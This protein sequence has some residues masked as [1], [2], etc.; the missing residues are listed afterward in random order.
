LFVFLAYDFHLFTGEDL[1]EGEY[2][3]YSDNNGFVNNEN[4]RNTPHVRVCL[5]VF[6]GEKQR[7][8]GR[9]RCLCLFC[10]C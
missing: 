3:K 8:R 6:L 9:K 5:F 2:I 10:L 7:Q 4:A 1:I